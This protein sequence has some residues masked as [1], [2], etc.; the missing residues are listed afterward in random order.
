[1]SKKETEKKPVKKT[2]PT[3]KKTIPKKEIKK[4]EPVKGYFN[5]FISSINNLIDYFYKKSTKEILK[6]IVELLILVIFISLLKLPFILFRDLLLNFFDIFGFHGDSLI[7]LL[8]YRIVDI[9]YII[10]AVM[11]FIGLF[12]KRFK[13]IK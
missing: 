13:D 11:L 5:E 1:M 12:K 3:E 10:F 9:I 7:A 8:I 6:V 4:E 2:K